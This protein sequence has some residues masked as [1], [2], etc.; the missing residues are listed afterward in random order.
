MNQ[1][2]VS[3]DPGV[4][5]SPL[6]GGVAVPAKSFVVGKYDGDGRRIENGQL[7]EGSTESA[8][9]TK[10]LV[11]SMSTRGGEI[12]PGFVT[13]EN[14]PIKSEL[15]A[16]TKPMVKSLPSIPVK[17]GRGRPK[18]IVVNPVMVN[19]EVEQEVSAEP[20]V[21]KTFPVTFNIESGT[22]KSQVD[23]ILEDELGLILVYRDSDSI[24]YVP[25]RGNTL[26]LTLP[27]RKVNAMYL[28]VQVQF[29]NTSQQLLV[30]V[31]T[32]Q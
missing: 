10:L 6:A 32:D 15:I 1:S 9:L 14:G 11:R 20:V 21:T 12:M 3:S 24:S 4:E 8:K 31:K 18:N 17:R 30:F 13:S 28:G 29:Y 7:A 25:K 16:K 5:I 27:G 23:A 2:H 22:I 19:Q 26:A